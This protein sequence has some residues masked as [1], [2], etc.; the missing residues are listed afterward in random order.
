MPRLAADAPSHTI[1]G[2]GISPDFDFPRVSVS[3]T[4]G[5]VA[6]WGEAVRASLEPCWRET[7]PEI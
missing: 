6:Q 4:G 3:S 7:R 5:Y 1:W 2:V